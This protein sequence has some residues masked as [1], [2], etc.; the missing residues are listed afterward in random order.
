VAGEARRQ[1]AATRV[2]E[3]R[4]SR[5]PDRMRLPGGTAEPTEQFAD[6]LPILGPNGE[7]PGLRH[8]N[9]Q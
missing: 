3:P 8:A 1:S 2:T 9:S 6:R 5:S 7:P 4:A